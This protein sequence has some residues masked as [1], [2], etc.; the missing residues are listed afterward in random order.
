L[1]F[2]FF[3][4][5]HESKPDDATI[6]LDLLNGPRIKKETNELQLLNSTSLTEEILPNQF[7]NPFLIVDNMSKSIFTPTNVLNVSQ[8]KIFW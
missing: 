5:S 3:S 4:E 6:Q 7:K 8:G 2:I 1:S